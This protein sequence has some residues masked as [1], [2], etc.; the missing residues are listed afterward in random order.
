[1]QRMVCAVPA[2]AGLSL[3]PLVT[4]RHFCKRVRTMRELFL[5]SWLLLYYRC[6]GKE[7]RTDFPDS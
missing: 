1:M 2:F 4:A 5:S 6:R 3:V 7:S